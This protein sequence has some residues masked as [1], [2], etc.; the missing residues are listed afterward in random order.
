MTTPIDNDRRWDVLA[1]TW[2][3]RDE[4][5]TP[6][7]ESLRDSVERTGARMRRWRIADAALTVAALAIAV[8]SC[9]RRTYNGYF[10]AIDISAVTAVVWLFSLVSGRNL[11]RPLGETTTDYIALMRRR[12]IRRRWTVW[13][14]L[15]L[16]AV[17][18]CVGWLMNDRE[19]ILTP[20]DAPLLSVAGVVCWIAWAIWEYRR[21]RRELR[22]LTY[23]EDVN[24]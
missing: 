21:T 9:S 10:L 11:W 7:T 6:S 12:V 18:L 2:K 16:L 20:T 23:I 15:V 19:R 5:A 22:E 14:A 8:W 4:S 1:D 24:S 3:A 13:L 17:Q